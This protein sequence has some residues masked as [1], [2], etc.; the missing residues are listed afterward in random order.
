[1]LWNLSVSVSVKYQYRVAVCNFGIVDLCVDNG[2]LIQFDC[3]SLFKNFQY[4]NI[5]YDINVKGKVKCV[6]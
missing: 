2:K 3:I 4:N 6:R 1:M 5:K